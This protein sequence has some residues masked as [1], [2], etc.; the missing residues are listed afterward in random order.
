MNRVV[1]SAVALLCLAPALLLSNTLDPIQ[2]R[3]S[4]MKDTREA[5]KPMVGMVRGETE[6][7]ADV[8]MAGLEVMRL[9]A[10]EAG[11]LFPD[12]SEQGHDT[13]AK[14]TIWSDRAGFE[15]KMADFDAAVTAALSAQP[16]DLDAFKPLFT[17]VTQSCK[18]CHDG[19][20]IDK[21]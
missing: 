12:G 21:D 20:R 8:V 16:Q 7:D 19:Y 18:G 17:G 14:S 6:Y 15:E 2:A 11:A 4:L 3:Q 10:Q 9:T 1:V 13:E 5:L